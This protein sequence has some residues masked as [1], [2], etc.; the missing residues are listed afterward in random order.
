MSSRIDGQAF[1][2]WFATHE[3]AILQS[4]IEYLAI[5]TVTPRES[6]AH[7]FLNDYLVGVGGTCEFLPMHPA[8]G[9]HWSRSPHPHGR[10]S[11]DRGSLRATLGTAAS[12]SAR[13]TMFNAHVDVVPA[14]P[15]F[16]DAFSPSVHDGAIWGRGAADTKNNLIMLVEAVRFLRDERIPLTRNVMLDLPAEEEIGGNGTLSALLHGTPFDEAVCLE[17]TSLAVYRGHRGCLTFKVT[18]FGRSVHMG[19]A[20]TGVDAIAGAIAAIARLRELEVDMLARASADPVFNSW[21]RPLQLNIGLINGGEWSGSVPERCTFT[22]ELGFLPSDSIVDVQRAIE[23][24]CRP[25]A[26]QGESVGLEVDFSAGL[27]NDACL[28]EAIAPVV[29]DLAEASGAVLRGGAEQHPVGGWNVSCD[30]RLY[31]NVA[32]VPTV[33]FG[34]G[35]VS[36]AHSAH[37]HVLVGELA[38]GIEVLARFLSGDVAAGP[39]S[40]L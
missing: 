21:P 14:S 33:V 20:G 1:G 3:A 40:S 26:G 10:L 24:A 35:S 31:A 9:E 11:S 37:E 39:T 18:V 23:G 7:P 17:P 27:C 36:D 12:P 28:T 38:R 32:G 30:A 6:L 19:S 8:L 16:P 29:S 5:D 34:S 25:V 2:R 4:L 15:D 22:G 13:T